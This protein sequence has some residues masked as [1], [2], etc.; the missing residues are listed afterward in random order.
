MNSLNVI[1]AALGEPTRFRLLQLLLERDLC[2]GAL[3]RE[4]GISEP[5]VSQH[6]KKLRESGL[7]VGEKRGYWTHYVVNAAVL[8]AAAEDLGGLARS[9][10]SGQDECARKDADGVCCCVGRKS[11]GMTDLRERRHKGR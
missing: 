6:L 1:L 5:A 4:L 11:H 2:V 10:R 7:V 3:A 9:V 8:A